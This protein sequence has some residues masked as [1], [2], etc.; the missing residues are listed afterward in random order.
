MLTADSI[1]RKGLVCVVDANPAFRA[2]VG[3]ALTSFYEVSEHSEQGAA[4]EFIAFNPPAAII[5]DENVIP[6]G[7]L[8]LLREMCCIPVLDRIPVICTATHDRSVFLADAS[9]LGVRTMLV[10]P[11][12]RSALLRA[13]S[14]EI[15]GSIEQA[16]VR[17]DPVQSAALKLT[18]KAFNTIADLV[19]EDGPL[20]YEM[21]RDACE[22]LVVAV[23]AGKYA[24]M[25]NAVRDHDNYTYVHSLRVAIFLSVFG[26]ALGI[27]DHDLM[28][29]AVGGLIHDVG[30]MSVPYHVLNTPYRLTD[31]EMEVMRAHVS[32]A[33][34]F[35]R[36]GG[37]GL[38]RG[39]LT[40]AEQHHEKLDGSGY[41][42][43]IKGG[44]LNELARMATIIDVFGALTDQRAY[45]VAMEPEQALYIM[46]QLG[47]QFD[48]HLL[49]M[50][51]TIL[52]DTAKDLN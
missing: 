1:T 9:L 2:E 6:R 13:L 16:W 42:L 24:D 17:I 32:H 20:P 27:K 49:A 26:H 25:L 48:Q 30:K 39:A 7:G 8:P 15:N 46:T 44:E 5:L 23:R 10:K 36:Q 28:T 19:A 33:S 11:F 22:P 43:G 4:L 37:D 21:V 38:P 31:A 12:R 40:I 35:L 51:R 14:D 47:P 41:P 3:R 52:L 29:L 50:F 34:R 18:T 45:K